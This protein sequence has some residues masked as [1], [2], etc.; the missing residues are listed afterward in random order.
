[1]KWINGAV[2]GVSSVLFD[3]LVVPAIHGVK[4]VNTLDCSASSQPRTSSVPYQNK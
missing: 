1:M 3:L 2:R 4:G